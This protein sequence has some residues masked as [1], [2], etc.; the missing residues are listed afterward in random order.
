MTLR[1]KLRAAW[2][3]LFSMVPLAYGFVAL[4]GV[5]AGIAFWIGGVWAITGV[6]FVVVGILVWLYAWWL[7][8]D[9]IC[10]YRPIGEHYG[11]QI[12]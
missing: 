12:R 4:Y 9:L 5:L 6:A 8:Y 2:D 10:R 3:A 11:R 7:Q 1:W